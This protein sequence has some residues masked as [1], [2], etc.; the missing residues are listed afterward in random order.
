MFLYK[1]DVAVFVML[2][3]AQLVV[4]LAARRSYIRYR[5][6]MAMMQ[7]LL[8][9]VFLA[10]SFYGTTPERFFLFVKRWVIPGVPDTWSLLKSQMWVPFITLQSTMN[11]PM[12]AHHLVPTQL[13]LVT[14]Q[15][16]A[17]WK[18]VCAIN[19]QPSFVEAGATNCQVEQAVLYA[20][21]AASPSLPVLSLAEWSPRCAADFLGCG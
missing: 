5:H 6:H 20:L 8:R 15:L 7:R 1:L 9:I 19:F 18:V 3:A 4:M 11:Y 21:R 12:H 13:I 2:A 16:A 17:M 10:K 14:I